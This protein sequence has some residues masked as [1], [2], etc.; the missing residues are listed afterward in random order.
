MEK[1]D[2]LEEIVERLAR[3]GLKV[4]LEWNFSPA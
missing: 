2:K 3:L 1:A 4:V